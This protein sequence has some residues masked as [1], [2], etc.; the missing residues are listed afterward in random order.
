[1]T[2]PSTFGIADINS[3]GLGDFN[4]CTYSNQTGF[5]PP[6]SVTTL[7]PGLYELLVEASNTGQDYLGGSSTN[8][9]NF[10]MTFTPTV[11]IPAAVWLFVTGLL[12]LRRWF[13]KGSFATTT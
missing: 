5:P 8:S 2:G 1:L 7:A 13:P 3:N 10:T 11:P 9:A 12:G 6:Y 4:S